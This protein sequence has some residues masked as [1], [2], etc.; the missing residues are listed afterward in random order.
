MGEFKSV[1]AKLA[2]KDTNVITPI[3]MFASTRQIYEKLCV[4]PEF[5]SY[6]ATHLKD[7][8]YYSYGSDKLFDR[9]KAK[10]I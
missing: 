7:R 3:R 5:K 10:F 1:F 8:N 6:Y 4:M 9:L 2:T